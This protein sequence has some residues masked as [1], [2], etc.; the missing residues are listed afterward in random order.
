MIRVLI[1]DDLKSICEGLKAVFASVSDIE[2]VGTAHDG[3][4]AIEQ[5]TKLEPDVVILDLL[6]PVMDGTE[7]T[8]EIS[9]RFPHV[10]IL[11][12]SSYEDESVV[13]S[14]LA[15]GANGYL[16]KDM[17]V[18]ELEQAIYSVY[19]GSYH[20]APSVWD[21]LGNRLLQDSSVEGHSSIAYKACTIDTGVAVA[22]KPSQTV[23]VKPKSVIVAKPVTVL[24]EPKT[25]A[26][27]VKPKPPKAVPVKPKSVI[28]AKPVR[29]LVKSE[30]EKIQPT[31]AAQAKVSK[32]R[33]AK[34][35]NK[36][37][38]PK[39]EKPLFPY[40]DW[41]VIILGIIVLSQTDGLGHHLG[42]AG[43]FLLMLALIARF[44]R[45]LW[46]FPLKH[47]RAVGIFAFA[48]AV[49]HAIYATLN[50]LDGNFATMFTMVPLHQSGMWAGI[51]SL[52]IM[53]PAAITSFQ[54]FQRRLG[55][56]WRQIHLLT[57]PA[58][59]LAVVHTIFI[60]PHYMAE[61][62]VQIIDHL[63]SYM[64][65]V[66]G[67]LVLLVRKRVFAFG[68]NSNKKSKGA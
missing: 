40:A 11:V 37:N 10:K 25:P 61:L 21:I 18:K 52:A 43:L 20:F 28:V 62:Q 57:V 2:I 15:A 33:K 30:T 5:I 4:Q 8:Q 44:I 27:P 64:V 54:F 42:H 41:T 59:F 13:S 6:M 34:K 12:L 38:K 36:S 47:R 49:A 68:L 22:V 14:V 32:S 67:I 63:R 56:K 65:I 29:G 39:A 26:V 66:V 31:V 17:I 46:G 9:K 48:A 45:P 24:V 60:G 58:L 35:P 3:I 7:A 1:V 51:I 23:A 19:K 55:K 16:L 53:T 50:V